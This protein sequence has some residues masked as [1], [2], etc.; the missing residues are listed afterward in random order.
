MKFPKTI[1]FD[2][3]DSYIFECAAGSDE[4]A[5][6]G[7]FEF[8]NVEQ[9][10]ISGKVRQAF[11]NGFLGM[12][13]FGRATIVAVAEIDSD[14]YE[15]VINSLAFHFVANYGAPNLD[16]AL[17]VAREEAEFA[18]SLCDHPANSWVVPPVSIRQQVWEKFQIGRS[19]HYV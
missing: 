19:A 6:S 5:V 18:A 4:W 1:R 8:A 10:D 17:P 14:T 15:Q 13:T 2:D 16:E 12:R 11:R 7:A 9:D 3:S